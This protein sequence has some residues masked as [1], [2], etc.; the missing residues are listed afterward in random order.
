MTVGAASSDAGG[1]DDAGMV[2]SLAATS[3]GAIPNTVGAVAELGG[4]GAESRFA[5]TAR[6]VGTGMRFTATAGAGSCFGGIGVGVGRGAALALATGGLPIPGTVAGTL[7]AGLVMRGIGLE[8]LAG[9]ATVLGVSRGLSVAVV[10]RGMVGVASA[11][12]VA[13]DTV[14]TVFGG[15]GWSAFG[16]LA[17]GSDCV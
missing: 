17:G 1:G 8:S 3:A 12:G 11:V 7:A 9:I 6:G 16:E 15:A 13:R 2:S 10:V 5:A 14:D 4:G